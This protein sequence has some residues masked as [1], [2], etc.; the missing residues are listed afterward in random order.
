MSTLLRFDL[1][2]QFLQFE[3]GSSYPSSKTLKLAQVRARTAAGTLKTENLGVS[4]RTQVLIL[5]YMSKTDYLALI[6]W[7]ENIAVG[8]TNAFTF[9]NEYG[10]QFLVKMVD[11]ALNFSESSMCKYDGNVTLEILDA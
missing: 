7:Y 2:A 5:N 4:I 1:G 9:T 3:R 10:E 11:S 8:S 6:N